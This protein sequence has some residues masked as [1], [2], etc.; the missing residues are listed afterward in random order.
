MQPKPMRGYR[1]PLSLL[2]PALLA[3]SGCLGQS[4]APRLQPASTQAVHD[5]LYHLAS[6]EME[7]RGLGTAG[8]DSAASYIEGFF[9][10][11]KL[12][13]PP[14]QKDFL[15]P[16]TFSQVTDIA[17]DT[18]LKAGDT[19]YSLRSDFVPF[20]F[21]AE[22]KFAGPVAFVGYGITG[23]KDA[24]GNEYDDYA[25]VDVKGKVV[26]AMRFEPHDKDGHSRIGGQQW[27]ENAALLRKAKVAADHGAVALL[28]VHPPTFH[29]PESLTPL[30]ACPA[31]RRRSR[32]CTFG[33]RLPR[34]C[35]GRP[36]PRV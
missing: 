28:V 36:A 9:S 14:G 17:T 1:R 13:P 30:R 4:T 6:D 11:L 32:C 8:L 26:L 29:G 20:G 21:S 7:G 5:S 12:T 3:A 2:L 27:S 10:A 33:R 23:T 25:G 19:S 31:R 24:K 35:S 34:S 15:Q 18:C 16:F 22:G